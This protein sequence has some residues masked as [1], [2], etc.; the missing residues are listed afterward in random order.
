[1]IYISR[2]G[3]KI[4]GFKEFYLIVSSLCF[5]LVI[6]FSSSRLFV[7][8]V[9]FEF[10]LIPI[11]VMVL[12]WGYQPERLQARNYLVLYTV[13]ASLPLLVRVCVIF[14]WNGHCSFYLSG[15]GVPGVF[16]R[17]V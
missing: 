5:I 2:G 3:L 10:S 17:G 13:G 12:G 4:K 16:N 1:M 11:T 8:Y 15:W 9:F 7:F 14:Y 6:V